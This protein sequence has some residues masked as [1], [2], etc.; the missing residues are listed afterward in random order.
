LEGGKKEGIVGKNP[1]NIQLGG[2][3]AGLIK[4]EKKRGGGE[5]TVLPRESRSQERGRETFET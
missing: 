3:E 4:T 5:G 1:N 2:G